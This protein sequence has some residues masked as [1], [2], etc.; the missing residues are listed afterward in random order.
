MKVYAV[1][2]GCPKNRTDTEKLLARLLEAGV[3]PVLVPEEADLL[4]VNTCAFIRP[5]VRESIDTILE[6]AEAKRP[7][8]R[9]AVVGCLPAR[10]REEALAHLPEVDLFMGI[11]AYRAAGDLLFRER[12][13]LLRPE[14]PETAR[15]ILTENPFYAYLKVT[16]GCRH[17]CSFC[18]IPRIRGPLRSRPLKEILREAEGLLAQGVREI[19]LVGQDVSAYGLD[20]GRAALPELLQALLRILSPG[21]RLRLLYLHPEGVSPELMELLATEEALAPYLDLPVQHAHPEILRRMRRPYRAEDLLRLLEELRRRR[22][23]I[24]LRTS[25]IVGFPGEGEEEFAALLSFLSQARFDHLGAFVYWPEEGTPAARLRPRPSQRIARRR[26]HRVLALQREISRE[27]LRARVG[28]EDLV[29][30]T[31]YDSRGRPVGHA[32]FQAPEVDGHT[33]IVRGIPVEPGDLVRVRFVRSFTY[34][35]W[36]EALERLA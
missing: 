34:D 33:V 31:G 28:T 29:L 1:S 30:V 16:E 9:L 5:A 32:G 4:V 18:T 10:F 35:L 13:L 2:L 7:G 23:G 14:G 26:R 36:A 15:R 12:G 11:E 24:G 6:L 22:P 25:V 19:I 17:G 3:E 8:Q 20:Q 21:A 27:N